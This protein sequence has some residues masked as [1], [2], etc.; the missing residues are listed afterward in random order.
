M[1]ASN[2]FEPSA[3]MS[4][5]VRRAQDRLDRSAQIYG[6]SNDPLEH[7]LD[8]LSQHLGA[9][10]AMNVEEAAQRQRL[11]AAITAQLDKVVERTENIAAEQIA[12]N[13]AKTLP[14]AIDR[15]LVRH[16]AAVNRSV[17]IAAAIVAMAVLSLGIGFGY[18]AGYRHGATD[19]TSTFTDLRVLLGDD[20][21]AAA[22]WRD[23][24]VRNGSGI[25]AEL[26][27]CKPFADPSGR[28]ACLV[29]LWTKPAVPVAKGKQQ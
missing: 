9:Q 10:H 23:L 26:K 24:I 25:E 7:P 22:A 16:T 27:D 13:V 2:G 11:V 18:L 21:P 1:S 8:A 6:L 3:E 14:G 5:Q 19:A 28:P 20:V 29:A 15:A 4:A 12:V 17:L